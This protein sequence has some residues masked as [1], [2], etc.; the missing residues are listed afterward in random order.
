MAAKTI[1]V[2]N[3][4]KDTKDLG[5]WTAKGRAKDGEGLRIL[6]GSTL[7]AGV[8]GAAQPDVEVP[9]EIWVR[10][11]TDSKAV[12]GLMESRQISVTEGPMATLKPSDFL[13]A[14]A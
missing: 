14:G 9:R 6:L 4:E 3:A 8:A 7:D 1:T 5:W 11:V 10:V 2:R 13:A 12:R